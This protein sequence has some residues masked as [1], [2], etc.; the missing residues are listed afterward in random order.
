MDNHKNTLLFGNTGYSSWVKYIGL[1][2][3]WL[4]LK[5][6]FDPSLIFFFYQS[7]EQSQGL[8]KQRKLHDGLKGNVTGWN[9]TLLNDIKLLRYK[10]RGNQQ[11]VDP[12]VIYRGK[13]QNC[14]H[15]KWR[16]S[17]NW[18][19]Q[20]QNRISMQAEVGIKW[21]HRGASLSSLSRVSSVFRS[22][23]RCLYSSC[24]D[25]LS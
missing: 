14:L 8:R 18:K 24:L 1:S 23:A 20:R 13:I 10:W 9:L 16:E 12:V 4:P 25:A 6:G 19:L 3:R 7:G 15:K 5:V 21:D 2:Q 22:S 11:N 17:H